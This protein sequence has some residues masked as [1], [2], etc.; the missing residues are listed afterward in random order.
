VDE[1]GFDRVV[2]VDLVVPGTDCGGREGLT[3]Y[4]IEVKEN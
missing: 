4:N 1:T 2:V 3:C